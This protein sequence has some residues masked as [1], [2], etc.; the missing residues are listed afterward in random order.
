MLLQ[1]WYNSTIIFHI[2]M[3]EFFS[4]TFLIVSQLLVQYRLDCLLKCRVEW[5]FYSN[6]NSHVIVCFHLHKK[7]FRWTVLPI[8][9][10][11]LLSSQRQMHEFQWQ[12]QFQWVVQRWR[13]L[14]W[15]FLSIIKC[16]L[17]IIIIIG[18]AFVVAVSVSDTMTIIVD[19]KLI[20]LRVK[21]LTIHRNN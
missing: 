14:A 15:W 21:E 3:R 10:E 16:H 5:E 11:Q 2:F 6:K 1:K 12:F 18:V 17:Y 4:K 13:K 8:E 19:S 7:W 9:L 20:A